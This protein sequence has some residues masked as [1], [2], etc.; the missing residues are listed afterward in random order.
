ML[1]GSHSDADDLSPGLL[2]QRRNLFLTGFLLLLFTAG[3][4]ELEQ[5]NIL[6]NELS[7]ENK[8]FAKYALYA[9]YGYFFW[10]YYLYCSK[11]RQLARARTAYKLDVAE[12]EL[13]YFKRKIA[14]KIS[15][16]RA[17]YTY[18][19]FDVDRRAL[20]E[21]TFDETLISDR[22]SSGLFKRKRLIYISGTG[23]HFSDMTVVNSEDDGR[24]LAKERSE[25]YKFWEQCA[26][27]EGRSVSDPI[28]KA[29]I[30]YNTLR[31]WILREISYLKFLFNKTYF[32][33]YALPYIFGWVALCISLGLIPFP[34]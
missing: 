26:P 19:A 5:I 21:N 30:E 11:E 3:G 29:D 2:R 9:I 27:E 6:G 24:R 22:K 13:K 16:F 4:A 20:G 31:L 7:I 1:E 17:D 18:P 23:G 25:I 34:S 8:K 15:L 14:D 28:F 32:S 12:A 10:R 33:D